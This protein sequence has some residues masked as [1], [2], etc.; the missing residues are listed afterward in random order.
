[1]EGNEG[2]RKEF[3]HKIR[4]RLLLTPRHQSLASRF[5]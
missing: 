4:Q 2:Y 5:S 3:L 1:M